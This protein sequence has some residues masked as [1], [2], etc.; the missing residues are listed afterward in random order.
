LLIGGLAAAVVPL[1]VAVVVLL[2]QND[3]DATP[4]TTTV[5]DTTTATDTAAET[6]TKARTTLAECG[7]IAE[8]GTGVYNVEAENLECPVAIRLARAWEGDCLGPP[9]N[10]STTGFRCESVP[11]GERADVTCRFREVEVRFAFASFDPP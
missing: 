5:S 7:D 11:T 4:E 10:C 1:G 3:G 6:T 2:A 8:G 9:G